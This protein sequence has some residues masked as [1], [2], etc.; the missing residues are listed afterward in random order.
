MRH[1]TLASVAPRS[2]ISCCAAF[3]VAAALGV[4][5]RDDTPTTAGYC[6]EVQRHLDTINAPA[7]DSTDDIEATLE[8]YRAVADAAPAAIG[9]EWEVL[10]G[11]LETAA[12]VVPADPASM[13]QV[14]DAA[15]AGQPAA[16]RIQ[17]YTL[18]AC[19]TAIGTPTP[20]TN[21]VTMTAPAE[22]DP[23]E[24]DPDG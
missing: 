24:T 18:D 16:T 19:G 1:V 3:V 23:A 21:P 5:C 8:V 9:P 6:G 10:I 15:L 4:A 11:G 12:T 14:N 7:I 20:T 22:T 2:K 13:A 17:Q